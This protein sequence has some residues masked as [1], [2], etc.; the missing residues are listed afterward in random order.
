MMLLTV[1]TNLQSV[2]AKK[3][4]R[5][6]FCFK[7]STS[8]SIIAI[9][10]ELEK[11]AMFQMHFEEGSMIQLLDISPPP[12]WSW[13]NLYASCMVIVCCRKFQQIISVREFFWKFEES[14][15]KHFPYCFSSPT[16]IS[17]SYSKKK[18]L[19]T[20][21]CMFTIIVISFPK[22][23]FNWRKEK[24]NKH[25]SVTISIPFYHICSLW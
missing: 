24:A 25:F 9:Y 5:F 11:C 4:H 2:M 19:L 3:V 20:S 17:E 13:H 6:S 14:N 22:G 10:L 15:E 7:V 21:L 1:L 8:T 12:P 18:N 23:F 16:P